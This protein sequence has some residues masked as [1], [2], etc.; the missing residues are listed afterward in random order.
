[1]VELKSRI[2]QL[3]HNGTM[4]AAVTTLEGVSGAMGQNQLNE[5]EDALV[6]LGYR[7]AEAQRAVA[8]ARQAA[9]V[10]DP[11]AEL[12]VRLA[13]RGFAQNTGV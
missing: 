8:Q 13:L 5:A 1:M 12:L 6:A 4:P 3:M 11:S 7:P 10:S 9:D 2:D